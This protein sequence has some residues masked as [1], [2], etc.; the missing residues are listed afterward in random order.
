VLYLIVFDIPWVGDCVSDGDHR[1]L[2]HKLDQAISIKP[3]YKG[4][5]HKKLSTMESLKKAS[6]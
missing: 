4:R 3:F 1:G 6:D 2:N 5:T